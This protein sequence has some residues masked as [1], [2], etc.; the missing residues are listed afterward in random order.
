VLAARV[1]AFV[2]VAVTLAIVA[3]RGTALPF[4]RSADRTLSIGA[5][6]L[7]VT[8]GTLLLL[9]VRRGLIVVVAPIAALG[10]A[11]TV[12]LARS[13]LGEKLHNAQRVGIAFAL[14]GLFMIAVG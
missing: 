4:P 5:G 14:V 8:A 13:V 3:M 2:L 6:I 7:D 9:A 10:P 1:A 11:A 12:I